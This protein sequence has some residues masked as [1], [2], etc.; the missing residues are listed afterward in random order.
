L[1]D[2]LRG[3]GKAILDNISVEKKISDDT[4]TKLKDAVETF[5]KSFA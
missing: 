4:K 2:T 1:L 5:A 3:S